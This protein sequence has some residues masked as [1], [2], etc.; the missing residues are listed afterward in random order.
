LE[1]SFIHIVDILCK[2]S[3]IL[4]SIIKLLK[5]PLNQ[6][7]IF[8]FSLLVIILSAVFRAKF[9]VMLDISVYLVLTDE[10]SLG[11]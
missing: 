11:G 10:G 1:A 6:L 9:I 3:I 4:N 7:W 8:I 2:D 5:P